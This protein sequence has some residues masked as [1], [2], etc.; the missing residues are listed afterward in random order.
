MFFKNLCAAIVFVLAVVL[1]SQ[2]A[3]ADPVPAPGTLTYCGITHKATFPQPKP[4]LPQNLE[5]FNGVFL[6]TYSGPFG[7]ACLALLVNVQPDGSAIVRMF[8][9]SGMVD[10]D[11]GTWLKRATISGNAAEFPNAFGFPVYMTLQDSDHMVVKNHN[12]N[13]GRNY[14][15]TLERVHE[16]TAA[17]PAQ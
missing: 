13:N 6:G 1:G 8:R 5:N 2:I 10:T 17:A 11:P 14:F 12:V 3:S 15:G 7:T 9:G 4:N 16:T